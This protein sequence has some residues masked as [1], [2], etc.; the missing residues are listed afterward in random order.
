MSA[1]ATAKSQEQMSLSI[2]LFFSSSFAL[3]FGFFCARHCENLSGKDCDCGT[4]AAAA[5]G[6]MMTC[7]S[8]SSVFFLLSIA[9]LH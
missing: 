2:F 8:F 9:K 7:R 4:A 1:G 5:R 3:L 6:G